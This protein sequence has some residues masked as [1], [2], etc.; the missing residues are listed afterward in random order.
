MYLATTE[1][2]KQ[3]EQVIADRTGGSTFDLMVIIGNRI[4]E[5][6]SGQI[7]EDSKVVIVCGAGNNGG[8]GLIAAG[9]LLAR[10][11]N[12]SIFST[13]DPSNWSG[14]ALLAYG[15]LVKDKGPQ[16]IDISDRSNARDYE[17]ALREAD[18]VLDCIFG[19]GLSRE[20]QGIHKYA[21]D[22]INNFAAL[23][24]SV[25]IPSGFHAD[26]GALMGAGVQAAKTFA[27]GVLK[28]GLSQHP[29]ARFA[30][31]IIFVDMGAAVEDFEKYTRTRIIEDQ[32]ASSW[33]PERVAD[34][35]K[36]N[37]GIIGVVAGSTGMGG[38][39]FL[40]SYACLRAGAGLVYLYTPKSVAQ[41]LQ[42]KV[43]EIIL[44]P[45][46]ESNSG[47]ISS[48]SIG[49]LKANERIDVLV[50]G[51][52]LSARDETKV[53]I[54]QLVQGTEANLVIDASGLDAFVNQEALIRDKKQN[55]VITPHPGELSRLLK[56]RVE[57]IQ[58]NRI[59]YSLAIAEKMNCVAVLKGARTVVAAPNG[60]VYV[61]VKGNSGMATAGTGDVLAGII[62]ALLGQ[63]MDAFHAAALGVELHSMAGDLAADDLTE[64]SLIASDLVDYLPV[65]FK[66]YEE[67]RV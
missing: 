42:A 44:M 20:V 53:A 32:A 51:P 18:L 58:G 2:S 65:A 11:Y 61:C 4:A 59:K 12:V 29:C 9:N 49:L 26:S 21:I 39:A 24:Y 6:I 54:R 34:S 1:Q 25:D 46:N 57:E 16:V 52:G 23:V 67:L 10:N 41:A 5:Y 30:G 56:V 17:A 13:G 19:S 7:I 28:Q 62:G 45:L 15:S 27:A 36:N 22:S 50:V 40:T 60:K 47:S 33:L 8:D 55:I 37:F 3:I 14:D 48:A 43:T 35:H 31:E 63:K 38:A 66:Y 64:Y